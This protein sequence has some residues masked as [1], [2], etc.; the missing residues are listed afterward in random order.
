MTLEENNRIEATVLTTSGAAKPGGKMKIKIAH[1][2]APNQTS[3]RASGS[4]AASARA[5]SLEGPLAGVAA[6]QEVIKEEA[7]E[8][9]S[10]LYVKDKPVGNQF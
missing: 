7:L 8:G 1:R 10:R 3:V 6:A 2:R 5:D 9:V 4:Q